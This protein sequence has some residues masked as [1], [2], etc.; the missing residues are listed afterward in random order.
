LRSLRRISSVVLSKGKDKEKETEHEKVDGKREKDGG[1]TAGDQAQRP[2][3]SPDTSGR[4]SF[5]TNGSR[6]N[7]SNKEVPFNMWSV[8][9]LLEQYDPED[10]ETVSQPYAYV[11]DYVVNVT[12]AASITEEMAKYEAKMKEEQ[13]ALSGTASP[14][15]GTLDG[16]KSPVGSLEQERRAKR[17]NWIEKMKGTLQPD[18]EV[19]W[20]VVV[21]GDEERAVPDA[22]SFSN[23]ADSIEEEREAEELSEQPQVVETEKTTDSSKAAEPQNAT[24][25]ENTASKK[26]GLKRLFSRNNMR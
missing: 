17:F 26:G 16:T 8:V 5:T 10:Q 13:A 15:D 4:P 12:L 6:S 3:T 25:P 18:A 9:K 1:G 22:A 21:C 11:A 2:K 23:V 20:F 7:E 24:D 19:G 14:V